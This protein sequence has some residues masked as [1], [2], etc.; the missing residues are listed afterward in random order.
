MARRSEHTQEQIKEMVLK[1]AEDI[2]EQDGLQALKVRR[3]VMDIG[4]TVG[5][6]YMVFENMDDLIMH[7]KSRTL[8]DL[9]IQLDQ[10]SEQLDPVMAMRALAIAYL[11][12]AA[13]N[14]HRWEMLFIHRQPQDS[15]IP[16]WYITKV[17]ALFNRIEMQLS[18]LT[19]QHHSDTQLHQAARALWSAIHGICFL[20]LNNQMEVI[21]IREIEQKILLLL[22]CFAYGWVHL[23]TGTG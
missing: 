6:V 21:Q 15:E 2:I 3:I 23:E 16:D 18:K 7:V 17:D 20:S 13:E 5:S 4:Y 9:S 1:S 22:D 19:N 11:T 14:F 12:F 10:L 8:D